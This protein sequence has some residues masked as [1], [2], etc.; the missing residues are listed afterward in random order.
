MTARSY[1]CSGS[2]RRMVDGALPEAG[3]VDDERVELRPGQVTER[4][5]RVRRV[6]QDVREGYVS[7]RQAA[8]SYGKE[9]KGSA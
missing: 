1:S 7:A 4:R 6:D 3:E 5:H 9:I 8:A 2:T